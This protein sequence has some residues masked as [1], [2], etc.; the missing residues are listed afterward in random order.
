MASS[1]DIPLSP[2]VLTPAR[3]LDTAAVGQGPCVDGVRRLTVA[4][5]GGV[6]ADAAAVALNVTVDAATTPATGYLTVYPA[7]IPR[8][9]ASTVNQIGRAHV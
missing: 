9:T 4:G 6:P 2:P 5:R 3:L 1:W 7:G 8:P